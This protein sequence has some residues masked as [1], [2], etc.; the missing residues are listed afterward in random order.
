MFLSRKYIRPRFRKSGLGF[1]SSRKT[2]EHKLQTS[3]LN[4]MDP[5]SILGAA[6]ATV[7]FVDFGQRLFFETWQVSRSASGVRLQ[8]LSVISADISKLSTTVRESFE[9]Q[10][11]ETSA[12]K[13]SDGELLRLRQECDEIATKILAIIPK[14]G[15]QFERELAT[16]KSVGECFPVAVESLWKG[17]EII[18]IG[19]RFEKVRQDIMMTVTISIWFGFPFDFRLR[20]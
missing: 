15:K 12:L 5:L 7:Q 19:E 14:V 20:V 11:Q 9:A 16:E 6:A 13:C 1:L 8:N 3:I 2:T 4:K 10:E 18:K 17:D